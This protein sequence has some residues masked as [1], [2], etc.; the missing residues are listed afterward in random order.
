MTCGFLVFCIPSIPKA[1]M[2]LGLSKFFST[3]KSMASSGRDKSEQ[4]SR[5]GPRAR[6]GQPS[7]SN[8]YRKLH[9]DPVSLQTIGGSSNSKSRAFAKKPRHHLDSSIFRTTQLTTTSTEDLNNH[10]AEDHFKRQHPW[11]GDT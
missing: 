8:D 6:I 7:D 1:F 11:A 4:S 3:L 9:G 2:G 5:N 10:L